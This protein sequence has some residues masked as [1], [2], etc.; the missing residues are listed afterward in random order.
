MR[1]VL[2]ILALGIVGCGK[3]SDSTEDSGDV[4]CGV[5]VRQTYPADQAPDF[6]Y[7]GVIEFN[8]NK[9]DDTAVITVGA[10][11][12]QGASGAIID[13]NRA[14]TQMT[15]GASAANRSIINRSYL[16]ESSRIS[17]MSP[18][19]NSPNQLVRIGILAKNGT[20]ADLKEFVRMIA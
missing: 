10:R 20:K 4:G 11:S 15:P 13:A 12:A 19:R 9:S 2:P 6:Y 5:E 7:K 18:Y 14:T 1:T 17:L 16:E 3:D 8:L